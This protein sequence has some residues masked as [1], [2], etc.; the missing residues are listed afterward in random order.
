MLQYEDR[1]FFLR[2]PPLLKELENRWLLI[3]FLPKEF[4]LYFPAGVVSTNNF[5]FRRW[6][7]ILPVSTSRVCIKSV[8]DCSFFSWRLIRM[9][10]LSYVIEYWRCL[11]SSSTAIAKT[12]IQFIYH[13]VVTHRP[14]VLILTF[15]HSLEFGQLRFIHHYFMPLSFSLSNFSIKRLV[16]AC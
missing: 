5:R 4:S 16:N 3:A 9:S 13:K 6:K 7:L 11:F 10:L 15:I 14:S 2:S 8:K 1:F 12:K